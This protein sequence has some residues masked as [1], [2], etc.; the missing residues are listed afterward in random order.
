MI[1]GKEKTDTETMSLSKRTWNRGG[2]KVR[3]LLRTDSSPTETGV[4]ADIGASCRKV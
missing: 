3:A 1:E 4:K 2:R